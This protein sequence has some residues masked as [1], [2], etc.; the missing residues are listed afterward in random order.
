MMG[1]KIGTSEAEPI[2]SKRLRE[3]TKAGLREVQLVVIDVQEGIKLAVTKVLCATWQRCH[4]HF[5][6]TVVA[7]ARKS[8]RRFVSTFTAT[9]LPERHP[10]LGACGARRP[11]PGPRRRSWQQS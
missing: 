2:W 7:H 10:R 9:D 4:I 1:M 5:M 11:D 6:R 3:L 8:E